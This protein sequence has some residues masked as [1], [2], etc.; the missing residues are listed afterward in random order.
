MSFSKGLILKFFEQ[1]VLWIH[2]HYFNGAW[3]LS[4]HHGLQSFKVSNVYYF[5]TIFTSSRFSFYP[6]PKIWNAEEIVNVTLPGFYLIKLQRGNMSL[7]LSAK[8]IPHSTGIGKVGNDKSFI[9]FK[10]WR[11][12]SCFILDA[13]SLSKIQLQ[14]RM[15]LV[16]PQRDTCYFR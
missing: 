2:P 3:S 1:F 6:L 14:I 4:Q 11:A 10:S 13:L 12:F 8:W 15:H 9:S 7:S 5:T 16:Q